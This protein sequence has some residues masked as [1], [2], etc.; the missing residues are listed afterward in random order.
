MRVR[1]E[2]EDEDIIDLSLKTWMILSMSPMNV[3]EEY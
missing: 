2:L 1:G 3:G